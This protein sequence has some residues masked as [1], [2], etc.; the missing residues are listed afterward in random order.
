MKKKPRLNKDYKDGILKA[1]RIC[2]MGM[3]IEF[4]RTMSHNDG[5]RACNEIRKSLQKILEGK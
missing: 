2:N 3:T 1:I 4:E 5:V